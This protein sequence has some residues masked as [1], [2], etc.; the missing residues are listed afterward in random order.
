MKLGLENKRNVV[1]LSVLGLVALYGV[2]SNFS[3]STPSSTPAPSATASAPTIGSANGDSDQTAPVLRARPRNEEWHPVV[4]PKNKDEQVPVDKIDPTLHLE[5]LA[6]AMNVAQAGGARNLFEF[7]AAKPVEVAALKGPDPVIT[8][9]KMMGPT[10]LPPPPAPPPPP[11]PP[12]D[13]PVTAHYYGFA[14]PARSGARRGFFMDNSENILIK[15]EGEIL[16]GRYKIV[17]LE[18]GS[19]T[20]Q[21]LDSKKTQTLPMVED[22]SD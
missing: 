17:K 16:V 2:Y 4:H 15:S 10:P 5:L 7:G 19:V 3:D 20:V 8:R 1:A 9:P 12:V 22:A 21:N 11:P 13:P 14:T 18:S 6:K